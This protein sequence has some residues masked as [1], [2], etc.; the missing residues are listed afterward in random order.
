[1]A[2]GDSEKALGEFWDARL[3]DSDTAVQ[4]TTEPRRGAQD[5]PRANLGHGDAGAGH[6][7][8]WYRSRSPAIGAR[9]KR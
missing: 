8:P 5:G 9:N 6:S 4:R 1:M 3:N 2:A 7:L